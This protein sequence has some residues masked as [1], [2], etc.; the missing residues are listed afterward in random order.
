MRQNNGQKARRVDIDLLRAV[1]VLAVIFFHF[2]IPGFEGG[3]LGVDIFFVISGYLISL[4]IQEQLAESRFSFLNFY[5]RR[6]RRI[7]PMLFLVIFVSIPF[8]WQKL[9]PTDFV[10]Q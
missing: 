8:A 9:L 7:L 2:D 5:E 10:G 3:F 6:A 1:A 4:H